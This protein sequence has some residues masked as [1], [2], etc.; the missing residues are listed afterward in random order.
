MDDALVDNACSG[1]S[2]IVVALVQ[3]AAQGGSP[4]LPAAQISLTIGQV[5][6]VLL[7]ALPIQSDHE[8]DKPVYVDCIGVLLGIGAGAGAGTPAAAAQEICRGALAK[9]LPEVVRALVKAMPTVD[10]PGVREG[11]VRALGVAVKGY[12]AAP[13]QLVAGLQQAEVQWLQSV[14]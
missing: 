12:G 2:K 3:S 6:P 14:C 1:V 9:L 7:R 11:I 4:L 5:L 10:E 13:Q 8:E